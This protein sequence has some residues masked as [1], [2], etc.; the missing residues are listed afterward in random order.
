MF[1]LLNNFVQTKI[2]DRS[3]T[4]KLRKTHNRSHWSL[5]GSNGNDSRFTMP[6]ADIQLKGCN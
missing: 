1:F 6:P 3:V 4:Q 5:V 2:E